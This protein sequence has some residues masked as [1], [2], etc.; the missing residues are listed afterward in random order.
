MKCSAGVVAVLALLG[1]SV[2]A[3]VHF[4]DLNSTNATPSFTDWSTA[5]TNIQ[6]A[7]DASSAGAE[8]VVIDGVL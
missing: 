5:P 3:A 2:Q 4:V 7:L 6:D 8:L 1:A